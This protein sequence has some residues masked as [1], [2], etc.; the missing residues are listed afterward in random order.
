MCQNVVI[1]KWH[2][3]IYKVIIHFL[4]RQSI[5]HKRNATQFGVL[6]STLGKSECLVLWSFIILII[7]STNS[8]SYDC[9]SNLFKYFD[10]IN[11]IILW[12]W[13]VKQSVSVTIISWKLMLCEMI[14]MKGITYWVWV[15]FLNVSLIHHLSS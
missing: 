12:K 2:F 9:C 5:V 4:D 3:Y 10:F 1:T 13:N 8:G 15:C 14:W 7:L 11:I 6:D